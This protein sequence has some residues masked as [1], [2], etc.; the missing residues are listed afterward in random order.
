MSE[1]Q[2]LGMV[3]SLEALILDGKKI[4]FTD[5]LIIDEKRVLLIVQRLRTAIKDGGNFI[6]DDPPPKPVVKVEPVETNIDLDKV[7]KEAEKI[8]DGADDYADNVL[9][10][11]LLLVT[12]LQK[13]LVSMERTLENGRKMVQKGGTTHEENR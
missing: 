8:K 10:Q 12:K 1:S 4:P 13:N 2:L 9:A 7:I 5:N 11:L 6:S 3:D